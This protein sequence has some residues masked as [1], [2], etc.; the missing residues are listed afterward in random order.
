MVMGFRERRLGCRLYVDRQSDANILKKL[1]R[2]LVDG[3]FSNQTELIKRGIELAYEEVYGEKGA[4]FYSLSDV[5]IRKL[6]GEIVGVLKPEIEKLLVAY[7][8]RVATAETPASPASPKPALASTHDVLQDNTA[9][10]TD[11]EAILP[12]QTFNFLKGLN[13]D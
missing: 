5:D 10:I 1:D 8:A 12:S 2:M 4:R 6:A 11:D 7:E 3:S 13:D 9:S